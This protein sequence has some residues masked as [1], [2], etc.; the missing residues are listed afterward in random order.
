MADPRDESDGYDDIIEYEVAATSPAAMI[1]EKSFGQEP[2]LY[3][4]F[5][6]VVL[7]RN[8]VADLNI[9]PRYRFLKCTANLTKHFD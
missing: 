3:D 9:V 1:P 4:R 2:Y 6:F 7:N 8:T 5:S